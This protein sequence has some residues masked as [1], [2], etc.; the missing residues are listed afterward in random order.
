VGKRSGR[1]WSEN[2]AK[3][4]RRTGRSRIN[5]DGHDDEVEE[6]AI[7]TNLARNDGILGVISHGIT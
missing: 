7:N 4:H 5:E 1:P 3:R 6:E 2:V